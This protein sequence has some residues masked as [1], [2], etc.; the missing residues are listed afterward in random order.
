MEMTAAIQNILIAAQSFGSQDCY[1]KSRMTIHGHTYYSAKTS[2]HRQN[3]LSYVPKKVLTWMLKE[4]IG[5]VSKQ[6]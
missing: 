2:S 4:A 3:E 5:E 1:K 6:R